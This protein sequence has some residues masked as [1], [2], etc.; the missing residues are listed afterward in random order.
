MPDDVTN[1]SFYTQ[2]PMSAKQVPA[3]QARKTRA[4]EL[5][6]AK[7]TSLPVTEDGEVSFELDITR[8]CVRQGSVRL[9][10]AV[11]NLFESKTDIVVR[12]ADSRSE[13]VLSFIP[14][15]ILDN[16]AAFFA[17]S[18]AK[19]N[20]KLTLKLHGNRGE[21]KLEKRQLTRNRGRRDL[22]ETAPTKH[23]LLSA[24][25]R[26]TEDSN[27][28]ITAAE[29]AS[30]M[31]RVNPGAGFYPHASVSASEFSVSEF[32]QIKPIVARSQR[33]ERQSPAPV[34]AP[35]HVPHTVPNEAPEDSARQGQAAE[36]QPEPIR[37]RPNKTTTVL[38]DTAPA[39]YRVAEPDKLS[40]VEAS[41]EVAEPAEP[42]R[43]RLRLP[44]FSADGLFN[45]DKQPNHTESGY[46]KSE[47][48]ESRRTEPRR[49]VPSGFAPVG[50]DDIPP[51]LHEPVSSP[52]GKSVLPQLRAH[53]SRPS[54]PAI[55]RV[56][57]VALTLGLEP[58]DVQKTL[59]DLSSVE[60]ASVRAIRNG[61]FQIL[62]R[63][64]G[65]L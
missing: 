27:A 9:P 4:F 33:T 21:I 13:Y 12:N 1:Q 63:D 41:P 23:E 5:P 6:E 36:R 25:T 51:M 19:A 14:P 8:V 42:R 46:I 40:T 16:L 11:K 45:R 26:N 47:H 31:P 39:R 60:D 54:T 50:D 55:L 24:A 10:Y 32:N 35:R 20:D 58:Q 43:N 17:D 52:A 22:P 30:Q 44:K 29:R 53:M 49:T 65:S 7:S 61:V 59:Q 62:K 3:K 37:F 18:N 64:M 57:D 34:P 28:S 38:P 15:R 2:H 48:A 56:E